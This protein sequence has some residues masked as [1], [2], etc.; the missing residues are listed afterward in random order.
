MQEQRTMSKH[1]ANNVR[2]KREYFSYLKEA[3]RQNDASV[4]AVAMALARFETHTRYRD[5]KSFHHQQATA[6]KNWLAEQDNK[7]TG[8]RLSKATLH[9]TLSH[10][11]RFF[12]WLAGQPGYKSRL[13]YSDAEYFNVSGKDARIASTRRTRPVPTLEQVQH[14]ITTMPASTEIE[15]RNRALI[16]FILLTGARDGAVASAKLTMY[17]SKW[18]GA[19]TSGAFDNVQITA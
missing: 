18:T 9:A 11:K 6:F 1:N 5:F 13:Q 14:V 12:H 3:K 10:L 2:I 15:Q 7:A 16:A 17:M 8:E 4:D 19:D